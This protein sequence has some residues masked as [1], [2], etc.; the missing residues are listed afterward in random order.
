[1]SKN[2]KNWKIVKIVKQESEYSERYLLND[3]K[4]FFEFLMKDMA[5]D[6]IKSHKK[7]NDRQR[8]ESN[9]PPNPAFLG[10]KSLRRWFEA[11]S[12]I[13]FSFESIGFYVIYQCCC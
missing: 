5:Y 12:L 8:E 6:N 9:W 13:F 10:L 11:P 3:W 4:N 2:S 1:M 7:K